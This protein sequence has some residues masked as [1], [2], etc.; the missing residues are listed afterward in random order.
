MTDDKLQRHSRPRYYFG[1]RIPLAQARWIFTRAIT[2]VELLS[3]EE[4]GRTGA[5]LR[6]HGADGHLDLSSTDSIELTTGKTA[7]QEAT[8]VKLIRPIHNEIAKLVAWEAAF[9]DEPKI[10]QQR[11][12][13]AA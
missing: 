7:A 5:A 3:A 2:S 11:P 6:L 12:V 4:R 1:D 10:G 13:A 8:C 9:P